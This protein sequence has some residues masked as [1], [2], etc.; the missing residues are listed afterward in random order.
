MVSLV[1]IAV[2]GVALAQL[3][4]SQIDDRALRNAEQ[5]AEQ[6]ARIGIQPQLSPED[7]ERGLAPERLRDLDAAVREDL[8]TGNLAG[9]RVWNRDGRVVYADEGTPGG[10]AARAQR[11]APHRAERDHEQPQG[12][13]RGGRGG[14]GRTAKRELLGRAARGLR[15]AHAS[16]ARRAPPAPSRSTFRTRR[17]R[18][19]SATTRAASTSCCSAGCCSSTSGSSAWCRVPR[20]GCAGTPPRTSTRRC[21]TRSPAS[22]TGPSSTTAS[23]RRSGSRA[24]SGCSAPCS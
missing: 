13:G 12:G 15:A 22:P 19:P 8:S 6:V 11:R 18:R 20:S 17:W 16:R 21:T 1:L 23:S 3:L 24:A 7:L 14:D 5:S 2:L 10:P 9:L 4:R